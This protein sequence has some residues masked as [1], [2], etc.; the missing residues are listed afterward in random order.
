[1]LFLDLLTKH[2]LHKK[3]CMPATTNEVLLEGCPRNG[4]VF[5]TC[6][7]LN[8]VTLVELN[9][10]SLAL[11][12]E[13]PSGIAY[14]YALRTV[15]SLQQIDWLLLLLG[16]HAAQKLDAEVT[17]V[18]LG[19]AQIRFTSLYAPRPSL[20]NLANHRPHLIW[21]YGPCKIHIQAL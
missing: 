11:T 15:Q 5:I 6:Q 13:C 9:I 2:F 10:S 8:L 4:T 1:L 18:P 14:S 16:L 3:S 12:W 19:R 20:L 21:L 17:H 7:K